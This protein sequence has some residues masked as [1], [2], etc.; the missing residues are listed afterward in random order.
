M[1]IKQDIERTRVLRAKSNEG[2]KGMSLLAER[3]R[4]NLERGRSIMWTMVR[5]RLLNDFLI[6]LTTIKRFNEF[7]ISILISI[8]RTNIDLSNYDVLELELSIEELLRE[9]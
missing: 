1:K 2:R 8:F 7:I 3:E 5:N 6:K 4:E 9:D